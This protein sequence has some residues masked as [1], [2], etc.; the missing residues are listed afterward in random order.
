[1]KILKQKRTPLTIIYIVLYI[2]TLLIIRHNNKIEYNNTTTNQYLTPENLANI[3]QQVI[4]LTSTKEEDKNTSNIINNTVYINHYELEYIPG[5]PSSVYEEQVKILINDNKACEEEL[6][7]ILGTYD[8]NDHHWTWY[9]ENV[10]PGG[11]L[12]IPGRHVDEYGLICDEDNYICLASDLEYLERGT[13]I[14]TP[15]GRQGKIYDTGCD[16][17]T[18]D[19]YVNW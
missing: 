11:G 8:W 10:L 3:T 7:R 5:A 9:S 15:F 13:V 2:C 17:G 6:F 4:T 19:V 1:M 18:I 12:D 14:D 16:Y